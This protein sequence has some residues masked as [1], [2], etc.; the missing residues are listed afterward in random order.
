MSVCVRVCACV[1]VLCQCEYACTCEHRYVPELGVRTACF[2]DVLNKI[3]DG[4]KDIVYFDHM[5]K[6][7][8]EA[9]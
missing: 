7:P 5:L 9:T 1:C 6:F 8:F 2:S 4:T 3:V